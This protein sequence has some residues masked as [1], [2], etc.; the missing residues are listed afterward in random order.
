MRPDISS[1]SKIISIAEKRAQQGAAT[2]D[3]RSD[4]KRIPLSVFIIAKNEE[5]RIGRTIASCIQWADEVIVIDSGSTDQTV[6]VAQRMGARVLHND[7]NGYGLQKRFGEDQCRHDWILNIDADEVVTPALRDEILG[8]FQ[9]SVLT[10][11]DFWEVDI[12][13]VWPHEKTAARH[14]FSHKQIRLYRKSIGRFSASSVHD[15]VRPPSAAKIGMLKG[16]M[17]HRSIPSITFHYDKMNRYSTMQ[18]QEMQGRGRRLPRYRLLFEF[19]L[20]FLKG[21]LVRGYCRYGWWGLIAST[22]YAVSRYLRLAKF[23]EAE[24]M[25]QSGRPAKHPSPSAQHKKA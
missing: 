11:Y 7:W 21:Y 1:Q 3:G 19:P 8:L 2:T 20:A 25:E 14:A 22:N 16:H 18:V 24:L 4:E 6:T 9:T 15:T 5:E 17:D 13:D 23:V 10:N 12:R